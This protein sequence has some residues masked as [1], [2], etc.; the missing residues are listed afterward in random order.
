[1]LG[2]GDIRVLDEALEKA[3]KIAEENNYFLQ[4]DPKDVILVEERE[5]GYS[6]YLS[7]GLVI[8]IYVDTRLITLW[9]IRSE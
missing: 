4:I 9:R 6:I 5:W 7:N 3:K 1:M 8:S 2:L